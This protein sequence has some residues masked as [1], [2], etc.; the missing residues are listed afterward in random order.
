LVL[1]DG[2]KPDKPLDAARKGGSI[3]NLLCTLSQSS[4]VVQLRIFAVMAT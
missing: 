4:K 3:T 2:L 1:S